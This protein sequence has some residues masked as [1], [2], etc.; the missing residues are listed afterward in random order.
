M[1]E[2]EKTLGE[3]RLEALMRW[4]ENGTTERKKDGKVY[5]GVLKF[6]R[7]EGPW[8]A[9]TMNTN[10]CIMCGS[11]SAKVRENDDVHAIIRACHWALCEDKDCRISAVMALIIAQRSKM[12]P[13][14]HHDY[15]EQNDL[16]K[17]RML[18]YAQLR[19]EPTP[20]N[21]DAAA[22][23][24]MELEAILNPALERDKTRVAAATVPQDRRVVEVFRELEE[25]GF[26]EKLI[27]HPDFVDGQP[28]EPT[29]ESPETER[30]FHHSKN[31]GQGYKA[32]VG[33]IMKTFWPVCKHSI[34]KWVEKSVKNRLEMLG[35][36][37]PPDAPKDAYEIDFPA[38]NWAGQTAGKDNDVQEVYSKVLEEKI[39]KLDNPWRFRG[40]LDYLMRM[41]YEEEGNCMINGCRPAAKPGFMLCPKTASQC[42]LTPCLLWL[43]FSRRMGYARR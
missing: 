18:Q 39:A 25:E 32:M 19:V 34:M 29:S 20:R 4:L 24:T 13:K 22:G 3:D 40:G 38:K 6:L 36:Q 31:A 7:L 26:F 33:D 12:S 16:I 42:R 41:N 5:S 21:A 11:D 28:T 1:D 15:Q 27:T 9:P 30:G 43:L 8:W 37:L 35:N 10:E 23:H 2:L 17:T 14:G